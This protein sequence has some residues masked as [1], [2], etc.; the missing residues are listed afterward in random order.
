MDACAPA[1]APACADAYASIDDDTARSPIDSDDERHYEQTLG[2][3]SAH[4]NR[5]SGPIM[6]HVSTNRGQ[7]ATY[8]EGASHELC[9]ISRP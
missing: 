6:V 9:Y 5:G 8:M 3:P 4:I 2:S 7:V 1:C